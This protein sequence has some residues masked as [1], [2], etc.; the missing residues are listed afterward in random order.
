MKQ[1]ELW[2][3]ETALHMGL[4]TATFFPTATITQYHSYATAK[5]AKSSAYG[6]QLATDASYANV[7]SKYFIR[8]LRYLIKG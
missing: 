2:L 1:M 7:F 8:Y 6:R 4:K 3:E 5:V